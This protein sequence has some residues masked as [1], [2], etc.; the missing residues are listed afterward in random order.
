MM[1]LV[2]MEVESVPLVT[3]PVPTPLAAQSPPPMMTTRFG[4]AC[5]NSAGCDIISW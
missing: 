1:P 2:P 3:T 5:V 4:F